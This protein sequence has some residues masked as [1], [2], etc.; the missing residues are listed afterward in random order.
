MPQPVPCYTIHDLSER[1]GISKWSIHK[2]RKLGLLSPPFRKP[3]YQH[4][5]VWGRLHVHQLEQL[6]AAKEGNR[7][8]ADIR[9][10][11][12]PEDLDA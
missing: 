8:L 1:F 5:A 9:D 7:S 12:H 2:Y 11:L 6:M 4:E 10:M 3:A